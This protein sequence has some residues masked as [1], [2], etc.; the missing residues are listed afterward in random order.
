MEEKDIGKK[1]KTDFVKERKGEN[2]K[3]SENQEREK[4]RTRQNE[5]YVILGY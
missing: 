5:Q 4:V 2:E 1:T 3:Q